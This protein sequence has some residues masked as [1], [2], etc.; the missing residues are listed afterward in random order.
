MQR[1]QQRH[2]RRDQRV[3]RLAHLVVSLEQQL[4]QPVELRRRN[5]SGP[6]AQLCAFLAGQRIDLAPRDLRHGDAVDDVHQ[7]AQHRQRL[8]SE[9]V[10]FVDACEQRLALTRQQMRQQ[11]SLRALV[12]E[13][14]HRT[15][16]L[17]GDPACAVHIGMRDRLIENREPVAH[18]TLGGIGDDRQRLGIG[19]DA[20]LDAYLAEMLLQH[21]GGNPPE[22]EALGAA[23]HGDGELLHL[24]GGEEE[25]DVRWRFLERLEQSVEG[26][27][28]EHVDFVDDVDLVARADRGIAHRL[29]DLADVVDA[30]VAGGIHLDD[31]DMAPLGDGDAG[32]ADAAGI[33]G[34]AAGSVGADAV[35][36][37]GDQ[38]RSRGLADPAHAGHQKG[39]RQP[40]ARD[41]VGQRADHGLLPDQL[42]KGL[43]AVFAREH[44]I[45]LRGRV[46]S[47]C[48]DW[49]CRG[50]SGLVD[51]FLCRGWRGRGIRRA[52]QR[53]LPRL[54][55]LGSAWQCLLGVGCGIALP[56]QAVWIVR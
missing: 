55:E 40:V 30:G 48:R 1:A 21:L 49:G 52:E 9:R 39:M 16:P 38:P 2:S 27:A 4:P 25:F 34:G 50:R 19:L 36:R 18:R 7:R 42:G 12:G 28:R 11:P 54:L 37:L 32:F 35:E 3:G 20:F 17:G 51:R 8:D 15:D 23:E 53:F 10:L 13:P 41:G 6:F 24:G 56:R 29:D 43:R 5:R 44:A 14:E 26:V 45:G 31:V 47:G 22:V 46:G 33:D